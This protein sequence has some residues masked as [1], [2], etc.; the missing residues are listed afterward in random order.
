MR[1]KAP[2][3][4][5]RSNRAPR[6]A[7]RSQSALAENHRTQRRSQFL[8]TLQGQK[9]SSSQSAGFRDSHSLSDA[10]LLPV[11]LAVGV[12]DPAESNPVS[13]LRQHRR[14]ACRR[15]LPE[16]DTLWSSKYLSEQRDCYR[17]PR[18][19]E[20]LRMTITRS[21]EHT[22]ELQSRRDLV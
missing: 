17:H 7:D 4:E 8:D 2:F 15:T 18:R 6:P 19:S 21:E 1:R 12:A 9:P 3:E 10:G 22:S 16:R 20:S 5:E 13:R 14:L 11:R